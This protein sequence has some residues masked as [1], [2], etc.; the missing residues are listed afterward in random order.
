MKEDVFSHRSIFRQKTH[1]VLEIKDGD[2]TRVID[3]L[4]TV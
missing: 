1:E 4:K 3:F 2:K